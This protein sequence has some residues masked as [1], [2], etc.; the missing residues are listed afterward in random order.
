MDPATLH[1][2]VVGGLAHM[3]QSSQGAEQDH[4]IQE[5][6]NVLCTLR[7]MDPRALHALTLEVL[8][9]GVDADGDMGI[10]G[11]T[12]F[13]PEASNP[14]GAMLR[15]FIGGKGCGK[16]D[17]AG[18][19]TSPNP[20]EFLCPLLAGLAGKGSGKGGGAAD[21][22]VQNPLEGFLAVLAG[23]GSGKGFGPGSIGAGP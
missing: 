12:S 2:L 1:D 4:Q 5:A 17:H 6:L 20:L 3:E 23:K 15:A 14:L 18:N 9:S 8:R 11:S 22:P 10:E 7:S 13:R 19:A 21:A 16:G